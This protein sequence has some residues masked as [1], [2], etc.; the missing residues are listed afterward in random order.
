[1]S[2]N[3]NTRSTNRG[4]RRN[5]KKN[6]YF[7]CQCGLLREKDNNYCPNPNCYQYNTGSY[8][9]IYPHVYNSNL[10]Y[11]NMYPQHIRQP[12]INMDMYMQLYYQD[13]YQLKLLQNSLY[14]DMYLPQY[15]QPLYNEIYPQ[16]KLD[17]VTLHMDNLTEAENTASHPIITLENKEE[18]SPICGKDTDHSDNKI[19]ETTNSESEKN[20]T[21]ME[22]KEEQIPNL[23][24]NTNQLN[25]K[26]EQILPS[27]D[28]PL[29][30]ASLENIIEHI[31]NTEREAYQTNNNIGLNQIFASGMDAY[32]KIEYGQNQILASKGK[33]C[34]WT[35]IVIPQY[36]SID[37]RNYQ[38]MDERIKRNKGNR[39]ITS[40]ETNPNLITQ[41][42]EYSYYVME[43]KKSKNEIP[44][45]PKN[46]TNGP[47]N[48]KN[49]NQCRKC[50]PNISQLTIRYCIC[51][52]C[53]C[54]HKG[55]ICPDGH[56]WWQRANPYVGNSRRRRFSI[57]IESPHNCNPCVH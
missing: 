41:F 35:N 15:Q 28:I 22:N 14:V 6:Y 54:C 7:T 12:N 20:V 33:I 57:L 48:K 55:C 2:G 23:K 19:E 51:G 36:I 34:L 44:I 40:K 25:N 45:G 37:R 5:K 29:P 21:G 18:Q 8:V 11:M 27:E 39:V 13:M 9:D 46:K 16:Q 42:F 26:V 43:N 3:T 17:H 38:I 10:L 50:G 24:K 53:C 49:H 56:Y 52:Y 47:I 30:M 32:P 31:L 1:M 4:S